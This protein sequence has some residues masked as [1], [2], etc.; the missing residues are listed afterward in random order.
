MCLV[1]VLGKTICKFW[2]QEYRH[3]PGGAGGNLMEVAGLLGSAYLVLGGIL[4]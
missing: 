4:Y 2:K 1:E 3:M